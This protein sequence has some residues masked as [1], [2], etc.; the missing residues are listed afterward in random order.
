VDIE[1]ND[2]RNQGEVSM[3]TKSIMFGA[4]R[5]FL[6]LPIAIPLA[7]FAL[8]PAARAV[9]P[10]PDGGYPGA[11]TAEGMQCA[12]K[13]ELRP[14]QRLLDAVCFDGRRSQ[15]LHARISFRFQCCGH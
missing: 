7:W 12:V 8:S 5:G 10:L 14:A 6:L 3:T 13:A 4:R 9:S 1:Q 15:K 2:G 11:N